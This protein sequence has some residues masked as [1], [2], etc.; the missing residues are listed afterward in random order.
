MPKP[1]GLDENMM[2][3]DQYQVERQLRIAC[4]ADVARLRQQLA[5]ALSGS[6]RDTLN[7]KKALSDMQQINHQLDQRVRTN[8]MIYLIA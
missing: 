5:D 3:R 1:I 4:E 6:H 8:T 2:L 7:L